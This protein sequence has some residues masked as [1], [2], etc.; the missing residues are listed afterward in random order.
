MVQGR[1]R[2]RPTW[3]I[4]TTPIVNPPLSLAPADVLAI[5]EIF[6]S[7]IGAVAPGIR[8]VVLTQNA[9][10][11]FQGIDERLGSGHPYRRR[12]VIGAITVSEDSTEYLRHAF[13]GLQVQPSTTAS[14]GR[15]SS[16]MP[17]NGLVRSPTCHANA[18]PRRSR[19]SASSA[20]AA[21]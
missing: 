7:R 12:D 11:S 14:I 16:A 15:S 1:P 18:R 13:P 19:C 20:H 6:G 2:F 8:R 21:C 4:N 10:L 5:P 17:G 3:F 9:Y